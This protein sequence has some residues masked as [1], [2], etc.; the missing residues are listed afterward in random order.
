MRVETSRSQKGGYFLHA[1]IRSSND[2]VGLPII[3][4][5]QKDPYKAAL[6]SICPEG[7]AWLDW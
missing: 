1:I 7:Q 3:D 5:R 2:G 4:D 6:R